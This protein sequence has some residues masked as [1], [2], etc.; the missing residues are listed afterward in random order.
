[1]TTQVA[2]SFPI[3][4]KNP[5]VFYRAIV[6]GIATPGVIPPGGLSDWDIVA[7]WDVKKGKGQNDAVITDGGDKPPTGK[8]TY[9]VWRSGAGDDPDDFAEDDAFVAM[10]EKA[11][12]DG[13]A[14]DIRH[15]IINQMRVTSVVR[16][17]LGQL[18]DLGGGLFTRTIEFLKWVE[19]PKPV[20]GGGTPVTA[21]DRAREPLDRLK[22]YFQGSSDSDGSDSTGANDVSPIDDVNEQK[23][24]E[25]DDLADEAANTD[26]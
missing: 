11:R 17:K 25:F 4:W 7:D 10:V 2:G 18:T 26:S 6:G 24:K 5:E 8:I 3:P 13:K 15:P 19:Q 16:A 9:Q 1:M 23:K 14:L 12:A 21:L 22:G 20:T